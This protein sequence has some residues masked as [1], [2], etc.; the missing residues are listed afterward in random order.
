MKEDPGAA[1]VESGAILVSERHNVDERESGKGKAVY[2]NLR[3][4]RGELVGTFS[5]TVLNHRTQHTLQ[6]NDD[7]HLLDLNFVGYLAHSC[8]PNVF[9]DLQKAE[10]WALRDIQ[11]G[12]ALTMDYASTEDELF[13]QFACLCDSPDCRLWITGRKETVNEEGHRYL[14]E[15]AETSALG[16]SA[17]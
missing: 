17:T 4:Q 11:P 9:V 3:H 1:L 15:F 6:L 16:D 10:V 7:L 8:S 12:E 14:R 5:G 2:T 13:R